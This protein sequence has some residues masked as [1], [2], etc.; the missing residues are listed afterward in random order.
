MPN[1]IFFSI[2]FITFF[3]NFPVRSAI[4]DPEPAN[5]RPFKPTQSPAPPETI[6]AFPEQSDLTSCP[7]D[8]PDDLF[9]SV[10]SACGITRSDRKLS[11]TRCCP[12]LAAWLYAAY[13]QIALERASRF[14]KLS[15]TE[16]YDLPLLPDDS[17]TCVDTLQQEL[18]RKGIQ[19]I[20][21]N[22]TCD[23][24]YCFCGIRLHPL[25]C[26]EA[27]SVSQKGKIV[28]NGN[29]RRLENDCLVK[30]NNGFPGLAGCSK[31]LNS[32]Y[33]LNQQ[34]IGNSSRSDDRTTKMHNRDCELMGLTWLL[35]KNRTAYIHTVTA[36]LR[37]L[38]MSK[39]G[40]D[41]QSC[42]LGSDGMPFAVDSNEINSQSA[43]NT[44]QPTLWL[45]FLC[46]P[47]FVSFIRF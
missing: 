19:I 44:L 2:T 23:A 39:D 42:T 46:I 37:A 34:K 29:V 21:P 7:L 47:L 18:V 9:R 11:E 38:M 45:S 41:P 33:Q 31:C 10:S 22:E 35:A 32:L 13:S 4:S 26:P 3:S 20:G 28:G 1:S 14:G 30:T 6:P 36:V 17:E 15:P 8:L 40:S 5:I 43:S 27:F 25:S 12:V 24:V 16:T